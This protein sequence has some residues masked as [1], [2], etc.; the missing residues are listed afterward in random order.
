MKIKWLGHSAFLITS[1]A[2]IK[3]ITDPY[4]VGDGINYHPI[5][6]SS[7]IVTISHIH[8]DHSNISAVKGSPVILREQGSNNIKGID[9]KAM[10]VHHDSTLGSQRGKNL[11]FC[12]K[13][14][15]VVVC[16]AGDLGHILSQKQIEE[17]RRVDILMLPIGGFYT[18]DGREANIVAQSLKPRIVIPMHY[19]TPGTEYPIAGVQPFLKSREN[20]RQTDTSEIELT[21]TNLPQVTETI[22]LKSAY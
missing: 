7:D 14:D 1:A 6:E 15:G 8:G 2:G 4:T 17:I 12:F 3:I 21:L 10:Q 22:V 5:N 13:I 11:I 9:I 16:H 19:K 18:I 20:V